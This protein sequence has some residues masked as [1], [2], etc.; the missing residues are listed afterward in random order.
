MSP[1][2]TPLACWTNHREPAVKADAVAQLVA[3]V[4]AYQTGDPVFQP[5][6]IFCHMEGVE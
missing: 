2:D 1:P 5:P 3:L 6:V 4:P